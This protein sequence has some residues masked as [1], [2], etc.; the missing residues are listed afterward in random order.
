MVAYAA[1]L[2]VTSYLVASNRALNFLEQREAVS[3]TLQVAVAVSALLVL[4]AAA[5]SISGERER[6]TLETLL[7]TPAPRAALV[8]GKAASAMSLWLAAYL[9]SAPYIWYLARGTHILSTALLAGLGVGFLLALCLCGLGLA[10]SAV[11]SSSRIALSVSL[12]ILIAVFFPT[13]L[14]TSA[15]NGWFGDFLLHAD[16]ITAGLQYVSK[17]IVNAHNPGDELRWLIGPV[18]FAVVTGV[19]ALVVGSNMRLRAGDRS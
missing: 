9:V 1:M 2:S 6:G 12:F 4:V 11:A 16:P 10:V 3:L 14:P 8:I 19:A 5:D 15:Q 18:V 13:Q 17:L 7:L